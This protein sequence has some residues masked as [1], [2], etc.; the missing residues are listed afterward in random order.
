MGVLA[1]LEYRV[2]LRKAQRAGL[3]KDLREFTRIEARK[4]R[5]IGDQRRVECGHIPSEGGDLK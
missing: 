1:L 4:Q 2:V 5:Q 3:A